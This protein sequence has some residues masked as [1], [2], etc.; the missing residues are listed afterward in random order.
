MPRERG[1]GG[2]QS[3]SEMAQVTQTSR[4]TKHQT[5]AESVCIQPEKQG[6]GISEELFSKMKSNVGDSGR[7]FACKHS[8]WRLKAGTFSRARSGVCVLYE[9]L[10]LENIGNEIGLGLVQQIC[11]WLLVKE[12]AD[13]FQWSILGWG[14]INNGGY[15]KCLEANSS[16][17]K[18]EPSRSWV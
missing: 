7:A 1:L 16:W 10:F 2:E 8:K 11:E 15:I 12:A 9:M 5:I 14:L 6:F 3:S 18:L 13:Y 4:V 17:K